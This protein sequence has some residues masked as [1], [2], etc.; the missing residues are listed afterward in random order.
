MERCGLIAA[1]S[2]RRCAPSLMLS[3]RLP[4]PRAVTKR[5]SLDVGRRARRGVYQRL[6]LWGARD[7]YLTDS[8][9]HALRF[10]QAG[11]R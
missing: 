11:H 8:H 1:G 3:V 6:K 9:D 7:V 10:V 5:R 4:Q 2:G